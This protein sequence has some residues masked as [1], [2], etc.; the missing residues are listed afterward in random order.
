ML[1]C[2]RTTGRA[3][4]CR[5]W[6]AGK[7][8][9][10]RTSRA[11]AWTHRTQRWHKLFSMPSTKPATSMQQHTRAASQCASS[12]AADCSS[13]SMPASSCQYTVCLQVSCLALEAVPWCS[14]A[15]DDIHYGVLWL[16]EE[17]SPFVPSV[18]AM[19][20]VWHAMH[21]ALE[22]QCPVCVGGAN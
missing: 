5:L 18:W 14:S 13:S 20:A 22:G 1:L 17:A 6:R 2:R 16:C 8:L 7:L 11:S 10:R 19:S 12:S 21:A 4:P 9:L 15:A 3:Q